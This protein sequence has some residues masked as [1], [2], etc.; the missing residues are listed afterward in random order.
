MLDKLPKPSLLLVGYIDASTLLKRFRPRVAKHGFQDFINLQRLFWSV[1]FSLVP[2]QHNIFTNSKS[3]LKYFEAAVVG[4]QSIASPTY[5]Y[6]RAIRDG[7]NGYLA[8]AHEW[9]KVI[10]RAIDNMKDYKHN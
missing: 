10:G 7:D 6:A 8:Q 9:A 1:E 5:T 4:T 2:L 3:E